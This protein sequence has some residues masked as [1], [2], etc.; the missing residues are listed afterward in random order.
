MIVSS[1]LDQ[2]NPKRAVK[3][4]R[5]QNRGPANPSRCQETERTAFFVEKSG[6]NGSIPGACNRRN[7]EDD[8][9]V[10]DF[11]KRYTVLEDHR[12]QPRKLSH[13]DNRYQWRE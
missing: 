7:A 8:F 1:A 12:I 2:Q 3:A 10:Y 4:S 9:P 11:K 5:L 13:T 6:R